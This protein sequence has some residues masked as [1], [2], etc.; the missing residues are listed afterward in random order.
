[1]QGVGFGKPILRDVAYFL[2]FIFFVDSCIFFFAWAEWLAAMGG[3]GSPWL[4]IL[5]AMNEDDG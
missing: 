3:C 4:C 2:F 5:D 1:V